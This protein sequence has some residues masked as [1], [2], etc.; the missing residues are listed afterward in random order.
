MACYP[1]DVDQEA[2]AMLEETTGLLSKT[3][4]YEWAK[5]RQERKKTVDVQEGKIKLV[6]FS[7]AG[8]L[9][10]FPGQQVREVVEMATRSITLIPGSP[11][12]VLGV[13]NLRG[14]IESIVDPYAL[15]G[16]D[17]P[18]DTSQRHAVMVRQGDFC[19]GVSVD[20]VE[21]VVDIPL[22]DLHTAT[23]LPLHQTLQDLVSASTQF[24]DRPVAIL[25][26]TQ[27][28]QRILQ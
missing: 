18:V 4:L 16:M 3:R 14:V 15:L 2:A 1:D 22:S 9:F 21:D 13:I 10:A 27:L 19:T 12:F 28:L 17:K 23:A 6:L 24:R 5:Q 11:E 25:D 8:S 7:L 20:A 26:T